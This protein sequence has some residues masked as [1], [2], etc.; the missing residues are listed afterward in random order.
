MDSDESLLAFY[1]DIVRLYRPS[2]S[3]VADRFLLVFCCNTVD[4]Y[5]S[6]LGVEWTCWCDTVDL[7][8]LSFIRLFNGDESLLASYYNTLDFTGLLL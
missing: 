4:L 7:F 8:R 1:Y 2:L 3:L 5:S 6:S